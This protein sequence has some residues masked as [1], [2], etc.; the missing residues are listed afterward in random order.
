M[1][2]GGNLV[3]KKNDGV[4][5]VT[6]TFQN[7]SSGDRSPAIWQ[8]TAVGT[9]FSHRP[10]LRLVAREAAGGKSRRIEATFTYP[11]TSVGSDGK[12]YVAFQSIM[13][14]SW[15]IPK[16]QPSADV[17]EMVA[18]SINCLDHAT[19]VACIQALQSAS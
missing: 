10:T 6:F 8:N 15:V 1:P 9:A 13:L 17:N 16:D 4:T 18:Q 3:V 12:T 2:A 7:P 11:T 19:I 14:A 5:D